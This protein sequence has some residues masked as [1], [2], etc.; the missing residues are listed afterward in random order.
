MFTTVLLQWFAYG[1]CY[2]P[3]QAQAESWSRTTAQPLC[4]C[5]KNKDKIVTGE[6]CCTRVIVLRLNLGTG[7]KQQISGPALTRQCTW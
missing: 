2:L 3:T 4:Y 1:C 6:C 7:K 5:R